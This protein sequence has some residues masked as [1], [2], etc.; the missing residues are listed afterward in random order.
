MLLGNI[1]PTAPDVLRRSQ[2]TVS[3]TTHLV[4]PP[5]CDGLGM[6]SLNGIGISATAEN[7][8]LALV[9][10]GPMAPT[11][12]A[13]TLRVTSHAISTA[14]GE[15][16]GLG[17][18]E[19][20]GARLVARPP[21]AALD[22]VVGSRAK[23]L[24]V[25]R[26]GIEELSR[27]WRDHHVEGA[28]YIEIARTQAARSA[29][30]R[31]LYD[32]ATEQL[33]CLTIGFTGRSAKPNMMA[34]GCREALTRGV[35]ASV[36]YGA[37]VLRDKPAREAVQ[38]SI[39]LG[40]RAR[41]CPDVPLNMGICDD[42]FALV[43]PPASDWGRRHH[44]VVQRSDLLESLIGVFESFWQFA[45]PLPVAVETADDI[46]RAST[47]ETRQLLTYLSGGLTDESIARELGVSER[48]VARRITRLQQ[49][50]GARTRFQLGV[51]ASR[52]GWL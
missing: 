52:R 14:V 21:R 7:A 37:H 26:D 20:E 1:R 22:A 42:R 38:S 15:L 2:S 35:K 13:S 33:R 30:V 29:V 11:E 49:M 32:E 16:T 25:L 6:Y 9:E 34:P 24:A 28:T 10:G 41:V 43:C 36:V 3:D 40:E 51:Q 27:F 19:S 23:E 5:A 12:L 44:I 47:E 18:V 39:D 4:R 45:V 50:L 17:L 8:Y 31:R 46:G 48:T